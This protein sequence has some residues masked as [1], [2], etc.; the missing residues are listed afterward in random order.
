MNYRQRFF[1]RHLYAIVCG[2]DACLLQ[3]PKTTLARRAVQQG[4]PPAVTRDGRQSWYR[5]VVF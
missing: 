4:M 5:D 1:I 2:A 3:T